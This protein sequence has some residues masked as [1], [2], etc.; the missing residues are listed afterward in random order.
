M[1]A[2]LA[3]AAVWAARE[4]TARGVT[5][6]QS[7]QVIISDEQRIFFS[8]LL[9]GLINNILYVVILSAA[10]D[11]VGSSTPK[12]VVL[13]ADIVPAFLIKVV[14]PFIIHLVAYK[15]RLWCLVALSVVGMLIVSTGSGANPGSVGFTVFGICLALASSGL[16][17]ITFL[18][19]THF[20]NEKYSSGGFSTGTGAAGLLGSFVFMVL[21]NTLLIPVRLVLIL[22]AVVPLGFLFA[23]FVLLP[24]LIMAKDVVDYERLETTPEGSQEESAIPSTFSVEPPETNFIAHIW[25]TVD[26][27]K[28]LVVPFMIP[29]CSVYISEYVINQGVSPTLLFPIEDLPKWLFSSYRD[30]YVVYGF[31][32]QLGVFISRS[33]TVWGFRFRRLYLLSI[34][35]FAN[36]LLTVVQSLYDLPFTSIWPLLILIFYEGLLGGC[37]YVNTFMSVSEQVPI[38]KREFSMGCV[39]ISDSFGIVIA[40]IINMGLEMKLCDLQVERGR[41]WCRNG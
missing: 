21:T 38:H 23:Y 18:L 3:L 10:I 5:L 37:L 22:F 14:A 4:I 29:L 32:Y 25:N 26:D 17:E 12:A 19:L 31:L 11:L 39:G 13:L 2:D 33:S 41:E 7:M 20:Y 40:G 1:L 16:G 15:I 30:I 27:I 6:A 8:F 9:F 24:T 36:L 35:Q 28:P 34:L